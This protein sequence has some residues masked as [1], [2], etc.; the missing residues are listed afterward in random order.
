MRGARL[1][2]YHLKEHETMIRAETLAEEISLAS[3]VDMIHRGN[4]ILLAFARKS[5][6]FTI[7]TLPI[8]SK[9]PTSQ[10]DVALNTPF[11]YSHLQ[12][13]DYFAVRCILIVT[14]TSR[15]DC[16]IVWI[17]ANACDCPDGGRKEY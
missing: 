13:S 9:K 4:D 10:L 16:F 5:G 1:R 14:S 12:V 7:V 8:D 3:G 2:L 15:L 17:R 11:V 6:G